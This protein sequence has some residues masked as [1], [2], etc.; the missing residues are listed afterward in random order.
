VCGDMSKRHYYRTHALGV[1]PAARDAHA[2]Q[3]EQ[4]DPELR[5]LGGGGGDAIEP[6]DCASGGDDEFEFGISPAP[7]AAGRSPRDDSPFSA[8]R[9]HIAR[10]RSA[11]NAHAHGKQHTHMEQ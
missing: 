3:G 11:H 8:A 1:C 6:D 7:A 5:M 2:E 9:L 10:Q 4:T